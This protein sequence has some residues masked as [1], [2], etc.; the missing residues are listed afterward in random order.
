VGT[1]FSNESVAPLEGTYYRCVVRRREPLSIVGSK[2]V[3]GRFNVKGRGALYLASTPE[4]ALRERA[5][6]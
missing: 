2:A 1:R 3:G 5:G 6:A 4:L